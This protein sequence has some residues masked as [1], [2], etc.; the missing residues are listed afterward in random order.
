[1]DQPI[2]PRIGI[3]IK[4]GQNIVSFFLLKTSDRFWK[5]EYNPF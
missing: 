3:S 5:F 1:M 2:P 4:F